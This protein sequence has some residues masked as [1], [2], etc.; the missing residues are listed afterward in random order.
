[1]SVQHKSPSAIK[2]LVDQI[3]S[4]YKLTRADQ[5]RLMGTLLSKNS[6]SATE[7]QLI[8]QVFDGIKRGVVRVID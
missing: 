2:S 4:S 3:I 6:L 8:N 5:Q 1:M 7:R